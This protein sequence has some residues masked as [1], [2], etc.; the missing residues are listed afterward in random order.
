MVVWLHV[1]N[2]QSSA[3]TLHLDLEPNYYKNTN[4]ISVSPLKCVIILHPNN[5]YLFIVL[6]N[7]DVIGVVFV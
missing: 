2:S 6:Y 7:C 4:L 1:V 5:V 3:T